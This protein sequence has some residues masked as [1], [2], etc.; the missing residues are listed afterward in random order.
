MFCD[1]G[2]QMPGMVIYITVGAVGD[3][4]GAADGSLR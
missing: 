1:C 4:G 3:L 2:S